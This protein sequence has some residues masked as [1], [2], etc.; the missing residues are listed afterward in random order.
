MTQRESFSKSPLS[1]ASLIDQV[2]VPEQLSHDFPK[3]EAWIEV[4]QKMDEVYADLVRSQVELE[5]KNAALEDAHRFIR[6]VLSSMTDVLIVCDMDGTIQQTNNALEQLIGISAQDLKGSSLFSIICD[7]DISSPADFFT[8]E[9]RADHSISDYELCLRGLG[10]EVIPLA[11]N[12]SARYNHQGR[13][14]GMVLTGRPVGELRRAYEQ[15]DRAHKTLRKTQQQL[16]FSEKMAALGRLVAGVAHELNNPISFVFGN[17]HAL[18]R[19]GD[20]ITTYL[21]ALDSDMPAKDVAELRAELKIDKIVADI[22]PLVEGTLE[23]AERVSDIVQDLRR[24]SSSQTETPDHFDL[25][26][27]LQTATKWVLQTAKHTPEVEFDLPAELQVIGRKGHIHQIIINLVQNAVD[28]SGNRSDAKIKISCGS[29]KTGVWASVKDFGPGIAEKD[30]SHIFEP[31]Y[32]TKPLGEGMGLGLYVSY[33][34][35]KEQGGV[36]VAE[37]HKEGGAIFTLRLPP[38]V[39]D[40][41]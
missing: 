13:L 7:D 41:G 31:F 1:L 38:G 18:K 9:M 37:N 20:N 5:K 26:S 25:P 17:M 29:D 34:M 3:E 21:Q 19:Y 36:L 23:G 39:D 4:I 2:G 35:A 28:V 27:V 8:D 22:S 24:F 10:G 16:I 6:S 12:C 11:V 15:L 30:L 32:T 40:E 33:T 14:K